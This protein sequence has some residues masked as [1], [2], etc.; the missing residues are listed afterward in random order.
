MRSLSWRVKLMALFTLVLLASLLLQLFYVLPAIRNQQLEMTKVQQREVARNVGWELE[1]DLN[2]IA[3]ELTTIAKGAE[4]R[5]MDVVNQPQVMGEIVEISTSLSSL[6]VMDAEGWFVSGTVD[7]FPAYT[8][9][10]Y[11]DKPYFIVPFEQGE[12]SF[13]RPQFYS[14]PEIVATSVSVPIESDTGERVGVLV[15]NVV[16]NELIEYVA[17]YPLQQEEQIAFLVDREGRVV[18]HSEID[19]FALEEGPLSLDYSDWPMVQTV[20]AAGRRVDGYQKYV[21]AGVSYFATYAILEPNG[22]GAVVEVP[23]SVIVAKS[24]VLSAQLMLINIVL[25]TVALGITLVLTKQ[26]MAAQKWAED[27]L[28]ESEEKFRV[29]M[30]TATDLMAITDKDGKYTYVNDSMARA[31]GYSKEELI[32]MHVTQVLKR[33]A[34]EKDFKPSWDKFVTNGEI[35]L[36]TTFLTKDGK[37]ICC[38][39]KTLAVY[40]S[41]GNYVGSRAVHRDITERKRM[42]QE[43]VEKTTQAEAASQYKSEFLTHMSHELRTPLNVIIGFSELMLDGVPGKV[44]EEQKQCLSDVLSSSQHLLSVINEVLDLAKI[45][46]G[47]VELKLSNIKLTGVIQSL[48]NEM[49]PILTA[50]KQSLEVNVEEGLPMVRADRNRVRQVLFN[51]LSNAS[52]FTPESGKLKVEVVRENNWCRISVVDNGIGIKKDDQERIFEQFSQLDSNLA[53]EEGGTGLGLAIVKQIIEKHGG[54]IWVESEYGNGSRFTFT[55]PLA[56]AA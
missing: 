1:R 31:L 28:R 46:S 21:T 4:F 19:L 27:R 49:M 44:N 25:F 53:N 47:E 42:E 29:F 48:R 52:K 8:T 3:N 9:K 6:L 56:A 30:E 11:A 10:S 12:V 51:L 45:E 2:R 40:D 43:L 15:G 14:Q 5:N 33:E 7:N 23:M 55:L 32:G 22:W 38:E 20:M 35:S 13:D 17:N 18:A 24:N 41:D 34:M 16:L 54:R 39:I 26:I 36:E 37:E 50:K